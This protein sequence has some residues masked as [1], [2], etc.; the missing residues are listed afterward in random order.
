[1][2]SGLMT[3][4]LV[5]VRIAATNWANVVQ[6]RL[7]VPGSLPPLPLFAAVWCW[8]MLLTLPG[9]ISAFGLGIVFWGWMFLTCLLEVPGNVLLLRS[10]KQTELSI[11]GP[12]SSF[13]PVISLL[14]AFLL[15][16]ERPNSWGLLGVVIVLVGTA[17]LTSEPP[18]AAAEVPRTAR[19]AGIRDRLLAVLLTAV[20][21]VFLKQGM[22]GH[23]ELQV[24][25]V[26]CMLSWL[27]SALWLSGHAL[28]ARRQVP[29]QP[30]PLNQRQR[31]AIFIVALSMLVMQACTISLFAR[32]PVGYALA[33]FQIGSLVS[34]IL[35]YRMFG[36]ADLVRRLLAASVMIVGAVIIIV[37][38]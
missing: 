31:K 25:A 32:M 12:L 17:L 14:V 2:T 37:L 29:P 21:S 28:L 24:L 8:M 13:K 20:A 35:G 10:L 7:L 30:A 33:L 5:A 4:L 15:F 9:W 26:W 38:G 16:G 18:R 27:L 1:M 3:A 19:R 34:V 6:K 36:E 11:F 23:S 22:T